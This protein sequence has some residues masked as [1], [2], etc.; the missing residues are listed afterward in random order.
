M[1]KEINT[2]VPFLKD[3]EREFH[4]RELSKILG[5]TPATTSKRLKELKDLNILSYRKERILDFYKSNL[6][7][8]EYKDLKVYFTIL[9][10]RKSGLINTINKF[11][12]KPTIIFFGSSSVGLDV[13]ESDID[14]VIISEKKGVIDNIKKFEKKLG[15]RLQFFVH[16]NIKDLKNNHLINNVL[17]GIVIQGEIKWI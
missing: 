11:Y 4:V 15:R 13:K 5:I 6:E 9:S 14:L 7:S 3:P 2:L 1:F 16:K 17:N 10:L 8:Q 12:L